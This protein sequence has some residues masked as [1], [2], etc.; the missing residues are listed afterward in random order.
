MVFHYFI[1]NILEKIVDKVAAET[2]LGRHLPQLLQLF[3]LAYRID[4]IQRIF[5]F[6]LA[7]I[8][9]HREP[10]GQRLHDFGIYS[11]YLTPQLG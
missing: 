9:G 6:Q 8:V 2:A 3:L 7:N 1:E 10:T 11:V 5:G 4:R